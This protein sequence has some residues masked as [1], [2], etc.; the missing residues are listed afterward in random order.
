MDLEPLKIDRSGKQE[1]QRRRGLPLGRIVALIV[2]VVL[3][4]LFH[5]P[6]LRL[7]D[8][9]RLPEVRVV[10]VQRS[11]PLAAAAVSGTAAN[12]YVVAEKRA[13]L[14][15]DTPGRIVEMLVTEGSR[16]RAGDV[17]A[18]LYADEYEAALRRAEADLGM[19]E[20]TVV[21]RGAELEVARAEL[22][23]VQANREGLKA[24]LAEADATLTLAEQEVERAQALVAE[25]IDT[26]Q[27]LDTALAERDRAGARRDGALAALVVSERDI[28]HSELMVRVS[29]TA[30]EES[31]L[32][33]EVRSSERAQ[34]QATLDKTEVRAPFD[35]IVVLKDA[36]VGEVVSPNSQGAQSRGSVCTIVDPDTLEVQVDMPETSL[37]AVVIGA[38]ARIFLDAFPDRPYAGHVKRIWPTANRQKATV[39]VRVGFDQPDDGLRSEMGARVVFNGGGENEEREAEPGGPERILLP[40]EC[41]VRGPEGVG[42]FVVERD[43]VRWRS[44]ELGE[45]DA[46]GSRTIVRSGLEG[47]ELVVQDPP[48]SL[49]DGDR[50]RVAGESP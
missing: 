27:R 20:A 7:A 31:R 39:E 1:R 38:P 44:V 29:Q 25:K 11:S 45:G 3:I 21:R 22:E 10:R 9:V 32:T 36:E 2:V 12:G 43:V 30:V 17:V 14:S 5:A 40:V 48:S 33:V 37:S 26:E 23:R 35:G 13:A 46:G 49:G 24:N 15:A 8:R 28:E 6:L 34:A 42:V 41:V 16:V 50:V 4:W 19:S 47:G 18:R